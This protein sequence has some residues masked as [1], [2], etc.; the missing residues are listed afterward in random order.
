MRAAELTDAPLVSLSGV[1]KSV[2]GFTLG[3]VD[4]EI[5]PGYV[6]AVLGPN[7]SGKSTLFRML[8]DL[9]HPDSGE[10]RLFGRHYSE[11][12]LEIK[13]GIGYVPDASVG[14]D[15]MNAADLGTFV[16]R[17]YPSWD[18]ARYTE[19]LRRLDIDPRK[20]FGKL[21]K[22]MRQRLSIATA[23]ATQAP[24]LVLDEPTESLDLLVRRVVLEEISEYVRDGDRSVVLATHI[25]DDVRHVAD[26]V[27]FLHQG[28]FLGMY[29]R[30]E[31]MQNWKAMWV[32]ESPGDD[33]PGLVRVEPGTP[34]R[35][36]TRSPAE[37][38]AILRDR[39]I[40]VVNAAALELDEILA[41]L[42]SESGREAV[43]AYD[44]QV[45]P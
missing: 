19:L 29:E 25:A 7:G 31:L 22:G 38:R 44:E 14:H 41:H 40:D 39:G 36:V 45:R 20:R 21:S 15:E 12:E 30:D 23:M 42:V 6:V 16:G 24:L 9:V 1:R 32:D 5:E 27:A 4:L 34:A 43:G 13:R 8:L 2:Q 3:A 18:P 10:I 11:Q 33:L 17:W 35:L 26:Y 37:T 28:E